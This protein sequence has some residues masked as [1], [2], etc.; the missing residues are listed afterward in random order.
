MT[1]D[2]KKK[3]RK[4]ELLS[5]PFKKA[6]QSYLRYKYP[7]RKA[8]KT[9]AKEVER[10]LA[11]ILGFM[12]NG[13]GGHE[14]Q[15]ALLAISLKLNS[16]SKVENFVE[17]KQALLLSKTEKEVSAATKLFYKL[18][19]N[20]DENLLLYFMQ[21]LDFNIKLAKEFDFQIKKR[22]KK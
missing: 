8:Q 13:I 4:T 11:T 14:L 2:N 19:N 1:Q 10:P 7:S 17:E 6:L 15:Y 22:K 12:Y 9:L 5:E 16:K 3:K 18:R 21:T 20:S